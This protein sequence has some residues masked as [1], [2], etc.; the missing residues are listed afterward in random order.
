MEVAERVLIGE[1][2]DEVGSSNDGVICSF[3]AQDGHGECRDDVGVT[4]PL[5]HRFVRKHSE[6]TDRPHMF[7]DD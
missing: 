3:G 1:A 6:R 2:E 4:R 5:F 7:H